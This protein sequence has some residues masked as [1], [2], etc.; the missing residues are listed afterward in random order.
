ML[1]ASLWFLAVGLVCLAL[2][3]VEVVTLDPWGELGRLLSGFARPDLRALPAL[4]EAL[5]NTITFAFCGLSLAVILGSG[6]TFL[7]EH[8]VVRL[9]CAAVRAVHEIFWAFLFLPMVGLNPVCGVL[10]IA[11]P[12]AG[13]FAKVYA[14]IL[15]EADRRPMQALPPGSTEVSRFCYG[16][17]PTI[18]PN[19]KAYTAY[20][21]ECALRSSAVLGFIGLPTVGFHLETAFREGLYGE[22]AALLYV[23]YLLIASLRYWVRPR[24]VAIYAG[25]SAW[26]VSPEIHLSWVN[27]KRFLT[28]EI[29]PWPMRRDGFLDGS[30][31]IAFPVDQVWVWCGEL[32]RDQALPG[33]W[34]TVLLTQVAL[35]ATALFAVAFLGAACRHVSPAPVRRLVHFGLIVGRTT[36]EYILA[37]VFLQ[38]WGPSMLPALVAI[39]LHNGAILS[40]LGA[41][42]ANVMRLRPDAP[43]GALDRYA[44]EVLPRVYGQF[45][46]FLFYRWEVMM[47]E[48]AILGILGVTTLGFFIDSAIAEDKLDQAVVLI[49]FTALLN[50]G[51]DSISQVV[52]RR[53]R[54]ASG[55]SLAV[56]D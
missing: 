48:S 13:V 30:L 42:S 40:Y 56:A 31:D 27:V 29:L 21:L 16:V 20:R 34:N 6:L 23:F 11:I 33:L 28:W 25:L 10:A 41:G 44:W 17:L 5:L 50:I 43:R 36:P 8:R 54:L 1:K 51:I 22:A 24:L 38:L 14:E 7:F 26:A 3:D 39:L 37:Y 53:L 2:A 32:V 52:R 9:G 47:R 4:G 15:Q 46:A 19:L 35:A 45:L 18:W 55:A 12:Y 49:G